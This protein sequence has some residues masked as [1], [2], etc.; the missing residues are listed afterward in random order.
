[1]AKSDTVL[2]A[3]F[4]AHACEQVVEQISTSLR[5]DTIVLNTSTIAPAEA[6][7]LARKRPFLASRPAD[8]AVVASVPTVD[9]AVLEPLRAYVR[10]HATGDPAHVRDAFLPTAHVEGLRD[11]VFVTW[12]LD[13]YC[14]L[15]PGRSAPDESTRSR[16][17]DDVVARRGHLHR[18]IWAPLPRGATEGGCGVNAHSVLVSQLCFV[19]QSSGCGQHRV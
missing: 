1:V 19:D 3:L 10:G 9:D 18:S 7:R 8:F 13:E 11:G 16:R 5:A 17:I 15:F 6:S 4:D 2:L 14:G 12:S